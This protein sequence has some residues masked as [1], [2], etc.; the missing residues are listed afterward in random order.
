MSDKTI[1]YTMRGFTGRHGFTVRHIPESE[2][3]PNYVTVSVKL[4]RVFRFRVWLGLKVMALGASI[5][6]MYFEV[7]PY[8]TTD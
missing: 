7:L 4:S 3:A 6:G 2:R 5:V 1:D 8:E